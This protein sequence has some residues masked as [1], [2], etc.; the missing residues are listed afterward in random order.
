M[1]DIAT[2]MTDK[3]S[4]KRLY[5]SLYRLLPVTLYYPLL[6]LAIY[7]YFFYDSND[8]KKKIKNIMR[9]DIGK[10]GIREFIRHLSFGPLGVSSAVHRFTPHQKSCGAS[11]RLRSFG[12]VLRSAFLQWRA[13]P[14]EN[15]F[16]K[17][18]P[19]PQ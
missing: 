11:V 19:L 5:V 8:K 12:G 18:P 2:R 16:R 13:S 17:P 1:T 3:S 10:R 6:Y 15:E 14:M 4:K 7:I 9:I